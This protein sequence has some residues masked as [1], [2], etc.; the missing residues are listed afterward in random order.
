MSSHDFADGSW[1]K[2]SYS[3]GSAQGTCVE[4]AETPDEVGVRDSQHVVNGK[5]VSPVI[6]VPRTMWGHFI[7]D[8]KHDAR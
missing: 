6:R 2:S 3:N 4:V 8:V 5:V 1:R 7:A